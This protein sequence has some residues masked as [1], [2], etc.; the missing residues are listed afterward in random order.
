MESQ[1]RRAQWE[2]RRVLCVLESQ[3]LM[4]DVPGQSLK[5][6]SM[7]Q[8]GTIVSGISDLQA[9]GEGLDQLDESHSIGDMEALL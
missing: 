2:K 4:K 1:S 7:C 6:S 3:Q 5:G 8:K 9:T